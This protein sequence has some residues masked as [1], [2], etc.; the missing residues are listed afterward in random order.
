MGRRLIERV[1]VWNVDTPNRISRSAFRSHGVVKTFSHVLTY[2]HTVRRK[3]TQDHL[4]RTVLRHHDM[5]DAR[6][7]CVPNVDVDRAKAVWIGKAQRIPAHIGIRID[8][9]AQPNRITLDIPP[10]PG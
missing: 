9:A 4:L 1:V 5:P 3:L 2:R 8:P 10:E 7:F 6:P